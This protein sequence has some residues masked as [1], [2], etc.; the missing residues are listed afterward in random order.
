MKLTTTTHV[1]GDG[2]TQGHTPKG[3][4]I[5]TYRTTGRPHYETATPDL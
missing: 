1:S 4:T 2:V 3:V 5:Q